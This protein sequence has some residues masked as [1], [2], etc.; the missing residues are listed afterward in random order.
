MAVIR[1]NKYMLRHQGIT[2]RPGDTLE[3]EDSVAEALAEQSAGAIAIIHDE[4]STT[5][6]AV[7]TPA[8]DAGEKETEDIQPDVSEVLANADK[9][10]PAKPA[11]SKRRSS[12][13]AKK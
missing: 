5:D 7:E 2:Y 10:Q 11:T 3:I 4:K 13:G 9:K 8:D 12:A 6:K 1:I